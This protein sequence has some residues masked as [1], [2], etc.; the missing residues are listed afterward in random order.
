[1]LLLEVSLEQVG[2]TRGQLGTHADALRALARVQKRKLAHVP[3]LP[4]IF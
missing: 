4:P 1:M 2:L 3:R